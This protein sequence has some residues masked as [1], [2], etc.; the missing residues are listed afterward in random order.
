MVEEIVGK[1]AGRQGGET[2]GG[3]DRGL[4]SL[5]ILTAVQIREA[6]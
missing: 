6:A 5:R 4:F 2:G 3:H 1:T